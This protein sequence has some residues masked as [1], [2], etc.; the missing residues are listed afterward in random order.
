MTLKSCLRP[1][2]FRRFVYPTGLVIWA[3]LKGLP[4]LRD[5]C[6][7]DW[8]ISEGIRYSGMPAGRRLHTE[9][10]IWQ[11]VFYLRQLP[12]EVTISPPHQPASYAPV[13]QTHKEMRRQALQ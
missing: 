5:Q 3:V 7:L 10:Q 9:E 12:G 6:T 4:I 1:G 11:I 13:Q 8:M 2:A